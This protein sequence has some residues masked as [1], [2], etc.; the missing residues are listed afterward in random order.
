M[1]ITL[2]GSTGIS[3]DGGNA[4]ITGGFFSTID[5]DGT[6]SSGTYTPTLTGGSWKSI[7]NNGAFTLAAPAA[8][9]STA[10]FT[11]VVSITNGAS[12]G[13]ITT[14]GFSKVIGDSFTTTNGHAFLVYITV[15]GT[16]A[17]IASVV[18]AQ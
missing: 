10:A 11:I 14:S 1:P 5:D 3:V 12:A 9:G 17:K 15:S 8:V 6:I 2:N 4:S 16:G 7:T 13:A 18:A